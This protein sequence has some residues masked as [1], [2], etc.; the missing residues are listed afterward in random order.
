[1]AIAIIAKINKIREK[2]DKIGLTNEIKSGIIKVIIILS[3]YFIYCIFELCIIFL[4]IDDCSKSLFLYNQYYIEEELNNLKNELEK[5]KINEDETRSKISEKPFEETE[6]NII[7]KNDQVKEENLLQLLKD[8]EKDI[9]KLKDQ[10]NQKDKEINLLKNENKKQIIEI[11]ELESENPYKLKK[12]EKLIT[13]IF[14]S[15][16][17]KLHYSLICKNTQKFALVE[18]ELYDI[19]PEYKETE[20]F[21]L[22]KGEEIN[23][24]KTIEEINIKFSDQIMLLQYDDKDE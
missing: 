18:Q 12:N 23:R 19:F 3:F 14:V 13:I 15:S 10:V 6:R 9:I 5:N 4:Y 8:K 1:M 17:Q 21:F 16:D 24:N 2:E 20:N 7:V 11:K 22:F